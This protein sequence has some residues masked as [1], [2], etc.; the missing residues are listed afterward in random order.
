MA[1]GR[2]RRLHVGRSEV[3]VVA[4]VGPWEPVA[5]VLRMKDG[6][7]PAQGSLGVVALAVLE[8]VVADPHIGGA[9][10]AE[11]EGGA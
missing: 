9:K 3:V 6:E 5:V 8:M 10:A 2:W 1:S 4:V 7:G 11:Q